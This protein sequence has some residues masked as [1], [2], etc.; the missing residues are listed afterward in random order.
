[1][2]RK[3]LFICTHNAARSRMAEGYLPAS[4][5]KHST[6]ERSGSWT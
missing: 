4:R 3:V 5:P 2:E 6:P 1:M